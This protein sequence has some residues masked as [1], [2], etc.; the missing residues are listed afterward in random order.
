MVVVCLL[1]S[2]IQGSVGPSKC[3]CY[4]K[5]GQDCL[6]LGNTCLNYQMVNVTKSLQG[7]L[8]KKNQEIDNDHSALP[9]SSPHP[10]GSLPVPQTITLYDEEHSTLVDS[11]QEQIL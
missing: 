1:I 5:A 6:Y 10:L 3:T 9:C 4:P 11:L 7:Y 2:A 8:V